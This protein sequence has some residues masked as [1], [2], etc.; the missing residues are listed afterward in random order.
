MLMLRTEVNTLYKNQDV[1][2]KGHLPRVTRS[3][4]KP[5]H[6]CQ[7]KHI[8]FQQPSRYIAVASAPAASPTPQKIL[9]SGFTFSF[10]P[11]Y[12][13]ILIYNNWSSDKIVAEKIRASI[14]I[15]TFTEALKVARMA[16]VDG[17]AI[18]VTVIKDDAFMYVRSMEMR[19]LTV[20]LDE[21]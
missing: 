18:V 7:R 19:G 20:E 15:I 9:M 12:R 8:H 17:K 13:V 21:A 14:P 4:R 2:T 1:F 11:F 5:P 10:E 3:P 16:K 6:T